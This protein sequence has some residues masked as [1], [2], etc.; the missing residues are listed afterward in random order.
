MDFGLTAWIGVTKDSSIFPQ[1][2]IDIPHKSRC[3]AVE[4]VVVRSS[5]MIRTEYFVRSSNEQLATFAT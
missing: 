3:I 1:N 2:I 5:A 4:F